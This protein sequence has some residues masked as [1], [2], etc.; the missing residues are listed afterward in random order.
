MEVQWRDHTLK[1]T[2]DWTLRWLYLAPQYELW[3]DDQK[4]DGR[5]GPRLRP[6]LEAIYEDE[7]GDLH[8]IEAEL[9]S[10]IGFRPYCE[11]KVEGEVVAADKVRVENFINPFLMLIIMASTVVMLYLGPD[12]IR[13]LLGL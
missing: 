2:G 3:L 12:M 4:L 8:H 1:V 6:L 7:D 11:I 10:V 9:V 5:G 13:S